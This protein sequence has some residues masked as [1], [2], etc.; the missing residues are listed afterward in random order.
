MG[1]TRA[2]MA[3]LVADAAGSAPSAP[4][5]HPPG[6]WGNMRSV[7]APLRQA[8]RGGAVTSALTSVASNDHSSPRFPFGQT[9]EQP[10]A[11]FCG[12]P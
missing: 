9:M 6:R 8:V 3:A 12:T 4:V 10:A 5:H 7:S 1:A 2:G 11:G